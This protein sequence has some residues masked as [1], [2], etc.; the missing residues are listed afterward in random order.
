MQEIYKTRSASLNTLLLGGKGQETISPESFRLISQMK[1]LKVLGIFDASIPKTMLGNLNALENLEDLRFCNIRI[2][3]QD[4]A[5]LKSL[6]RLKTLYLFHTLVTDQAIE[7]LRALPELEDMVLVQ[8]K[9]TPQGIKEITRMPKMKHL[10]LTEVL[11]TP[12]AMKELEHEHPALEI[13]L[14]SKDIE[15][16]QFHNFPPEDDRP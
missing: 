11:I 9:L 2:T 14:M 4:V 5:A 3:D 15:R 13:R 7:S 8:N 12:E 1:G 16:G 10:M 6:K